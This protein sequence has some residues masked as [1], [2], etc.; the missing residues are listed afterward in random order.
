M[1]KAELLDRVKSILLCALDL[2][3]DLGGLTS[4]ALDKVGRWATVMM[5]E[6]SDN[7]CRARY[8][9]RELRELL[10][11]DHYLQKWRMPKR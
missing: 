5:Y 7:D 2:D 8:A 4:A 3:I 10:P 1:K 11:K 9:P 6:A